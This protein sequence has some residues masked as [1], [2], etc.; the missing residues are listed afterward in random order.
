MLTCRQQNILDMLIEH[1]IGGASPISSSFLS[2]SGSFD[3]SPA[4]IRAEMAN[5]EDMGFLQQPHTSAGRIPTDN[6]YRLFVE[7]HQSRWSLS[8]KILEK[9]STISHLW[10]HDTL[11]A[12]ERV[13]DDIAVFSQGTSIV[14]LTVGNQAVFLQR[15][16]NFRLQ[17]E[18]YY[19]DVVGEMLS[20]IE[21]IEKKRNELLRFVDSG[22]TSVLIAKDIH[23][24]AFNFLSMVMRPWRNRHTSASG[25]VATIGPLRMHYEQAVPTID[26]MGEMLSGFEEE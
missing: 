17:P 1:Y 25:F 6:A 2:R 12:L 3:I 9:L 13:A 4:T 5:L 21:T 16:S 26:Y 7:R 24:G 20:A 10:K 22:K 8:K 19:P 14:T 15:F 23:F 18:F 11:S